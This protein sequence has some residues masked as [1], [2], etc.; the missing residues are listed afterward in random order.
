MSLWCCGPAAAAA[1]AESTKDEPAGE[2]P[3][4][5][6]LLMLADLV[7]NGFPLADAL[8][9]KSYLGNLVVSQSVGCQG[10]RAGTMCS[11]S[12]L[13]NEPAWLQDAI[14]W[15]CFSADDQASCTCNSAPHV[16]AVCKRC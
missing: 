14:V 5:W 16:S 1:P 13:R 8:S 12:T 7:Y 6:K 11:C 9:L 3:G 15:C 2:A 10:W 4:A